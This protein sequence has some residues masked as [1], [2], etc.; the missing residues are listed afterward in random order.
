MSTRVAINDRGRTVTIEAGTESYWPFSIS[1][2]GSL[3]GQERLTEKNR[4][5][6]KEED[7]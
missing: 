2:Y 7:I 1:T 5:P 4:G 6:F 3:V